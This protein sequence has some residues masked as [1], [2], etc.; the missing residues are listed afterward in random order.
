MVKTKTPNKQHETFL[1]KY[2]P[3]IAKLAKAILS[4]MQKR[5]PHANR[6]VYDN[7]NYLVI[8][9]CPTERPSE[10]IFSIVLSPRHVSLCF[11][12]GATLT[13]SEKILKGS[14]NQVR[15]L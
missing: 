6:M 15:N 7:Y 4:K 14:G 8:G 12:F 1:A 5:L 10:A 13:D 11:I 3:D 2:T 9:F